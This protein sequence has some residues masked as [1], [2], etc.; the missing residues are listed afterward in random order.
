M[1]MTA[2]TITHDASSLQPLTTSRRRSPLTA[3]VRRAFADARTRTIAFAY[4]FAAYGW[5]Q[6]KG[7]HS[8]YPTLADRMA[9]ARTFAG[10]DAIR[11]FYGYPYDVVTI[12]GYAAWRVGGT[13]AL[14]AAAFGVLAAVRA[15]RTEEEAG[16][17]EIVLAGTVSRMIAFT[18]SMIAIAL[19]VAILWAAELVG[20][21]IGGLPFGGSAYLALATASVVVV[22]VGIGAVASQLASSRRTALALGIGA[23]ALF[24]LLR[25]VSD[26][27]GGAEW[28]RWV[29]P[30]GW[31]EELRPF[32]GPHP[33]ILVLPAVATV[34]LLLVAARMSRTR[35]VGTGLVPTKDTA[36]PSSRLLSSPTALALR[37]QRGVLAAWVLGI[38][39]FAVV[40]GAIST[41]VSAAGISSK[42]QKEFAKFGSGSIVT[43]VGYLSFVFIVF[44]FAMCLF[45]CSQMG[46]ARQEEADQ[47]LETLLA[48]PTS[49]YRWLGGRLL[50]AAVAVCF[51]A[52]LGGLVAWAG[53]ASQG[54][55]VSLPQLLEAGAN[56]IP[57]SLMVLG[58]AALI[59][60]VLPRA[61]SAISYSLVTVMFLWYLVGSLL[62]VP[63]WLVDLTPFRHIGL[64][65]TQS[66]EVEAA[67]VMVAVGVA[68][69]TAALVCFRRRDLL[70]Y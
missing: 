14:A 51:L 41:S 43:P 6:A 44:I 53:S 37:R 23:A 68:A 10:N 70:G 32:A 55:A 42:L 60:S 16:R 21:L 40:L 30:L 29:T 2:S 3:L 18:S 13:L 4:V 66:F 24:W 27:V 58:V 7:Y 49:R 57:I 15:L 36:R 65:P 38:A 45:A 20:F 33:L 25:V 31:A 56:C 64:V 52:G 46:F 47:Q 69:A 17:A 26:I 62:G 11:L 50:L 54:V 48:Q 9:F 22:F 34:P 35:D 59:Y 19:G 63:Q 5:L 61:S 1:A 28:V 8:A 39:A 67:L 12:G